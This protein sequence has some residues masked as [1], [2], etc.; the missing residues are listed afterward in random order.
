MLKGAVSA[1]CSVSVFQSEVADLLG[2]VD[3]VLITLYL[4]TG[5]PVLDYL[6]G[7]FLLALFTVILGEFTISLLFRINRKHLDRLNNRLVETYDLSIHAYQSGDRKSYAACN[8]EANDAF[9]HV[10]FNMVALSAA[11]LW[12]IFF[13]L[14]WMQLRFM[15]IKFP[16]PLTGWSVNYVV[17]FLVCYILARMVFGRV[18]HRLPYFRDVCATLKDY[19][20][21]NP[22]M[23]S[24]AEPV[25]GKGQYPASQNQ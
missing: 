18:K 14:A 6:I 10:F 2:A 21:E 11:S 15:G 22:R 9:G 7:T 19:E 17:T 4:V 1:F 20:K 5:H 24:V 3:S 23:A 13:A 25:S 12:P 8:K 16:I